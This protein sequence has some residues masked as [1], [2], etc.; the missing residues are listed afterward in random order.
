MPPTKQHPI[1]SLMERALDGLDDQGLNGLDDRQFQAV[2]MHY[3]IAAVRNGNGHRS[4]RQ[5][6][7]L[8]TAATTVFG[9]FGIGIGTGVAKVLGG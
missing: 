2:L 7:G 8:I 5:W 4:K 3:V 1:E 9:A 6:A